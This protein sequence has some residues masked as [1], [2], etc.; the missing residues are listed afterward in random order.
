MIDANCCNLFRSGFRQVLT[1]LAISGIIPAVERHGV[2]TTNAFAALL[3]WVGC[4]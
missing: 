1:A 2:L 4:L 3:T